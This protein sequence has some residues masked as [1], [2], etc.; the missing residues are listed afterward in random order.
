VPDQNYLDHTE[1]AE[2]L[3]QLASEWK[4]VM[5]NERSVVQT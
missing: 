1:A 3:K 4:D 2:R 5:A